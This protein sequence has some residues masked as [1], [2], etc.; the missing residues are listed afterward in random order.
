[1][2]DNRAFLKAG[3]ARVYINPEVV[4]ATGERQVEEGCLS[5]PGYRAHILR[6][7][8]VKVRA[9]DRHG[10]PVKVKAEGI[11][12]QAL[13]H[14]IDHLNGILYLDHLK[15]HEDLWKL[16]ER[17]DASPSQADAQPASSVGAGLG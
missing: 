4:E 10:K 1:M 7:E 16:E 13:E 2:K 15:S 11:L 14:E 5:V 12:A 9:L 3:E 6:S 8:S 17:N